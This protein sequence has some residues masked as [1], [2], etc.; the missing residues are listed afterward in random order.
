VRHILESRLRSAA[1]AFPRATWVEIGAL[2]ALVAVAA[3]LRLVDLTTLP[4]GFH[5]DEAIAG[6]EAQRVLDT[7]NIG[8]YSPSALGQPA[9]PLYGLAAFVWAFG[10][11]IFAVRL[12]SAVVGI[13]AVPALYL[14]VRRSF[15]VPTALVA[16][17]FLAVAGW[18]IHFS[19]IGYPVA[20]WPL[21]VILASGALAEAVRG[22]RMRWWLAAGALWSGGLYVYNAHLILMVI[23]AVFLLCY[24]VVHRYAPLRKDLAALALFALG[25]IVV[26]WPMVS[27]ARDERNGYFNHFDNQSLTRTVEWKALTTPAERVEF[28]VGRYRDAWTT[29]TFEPR[30]DAVDASGATEVIPPA[31]LLLALFGAG[32]ASLRRRRALL[33]IAIVVIL[34]TPLTATLTQ[35]GLA[36]RSFA[37]SPFISLLCALGVVESVRACREL[38]AWPKRAGASLA[39][40]FVAIAVYQN[41]HGYFG[42]FRDNQDRHWAFATE[43]E[44]ALSYVQAGPED[45]YV[46]FF[47]ERWPLNYE[48]RQFLAP[49]LQ[50]ED[51]S[52]EHA[53]FDLRTDR[54]HGDLVFIL[55][56]RY[57]RSLD[58]IQQWYPGGEVTRGGQWRS[59]GFV[60]YRV[61][62]PP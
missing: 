14:V 47:S 4:T 3:I 25:A 9:G 38:G 42:T 5:G 23:V 56:G 22:G 60:A 51:R 16:A 12:F 35:G 7:G 2:F 17:G 40:A 29:L 45:T 61:A 37:M 15:D 11:S 48:V 49:G 24:L 18:N 58:E 30:F 46:Y 62:A 19:R 10:H 28:L 36:R 34:L 31:A 13:L 52:N 57:M 44:A 33:G 32:V 21:A 27:Y 26:A 8:P 1:S 43:F 20:A 54:K 6:M 59:G 55:M 50:G 53:Q 39:G 41:V